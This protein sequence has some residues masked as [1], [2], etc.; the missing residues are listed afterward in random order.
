MNATSQTAPIIENGR[1]IHYLKCWPESFDAIAAGVKRQDIR[2]ND[3]GFRCGDIVRFCKFDPQSDQFLKPRHDSVVTHITTSAQL[4]RQFRG[5]L[6]REMVVLSIADAEP[7]QEYECADKSG[8]CQRWP[9]CKCDPKAVK[10][11]EL[12]IE[13]GLAIRP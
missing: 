8:A 2:S 10:V 7:R 12:L 9:T 11:Y 3:R 5:G 1:R 6:A 4:E 13:R